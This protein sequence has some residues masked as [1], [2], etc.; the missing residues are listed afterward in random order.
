MADAAG[1]QAGALKD[2]QPAVTD[3][4]YLETKEYL[5]SWYLLDVDSEQRA[6]EIAAELPTAV[7]PADRGVADP[8]RGLQ[9]DR[10]RYGRRLTTMPDA[11]SAE[12]LLR[13]LAPQVL[14]VLMRRYDGLDSCEDAVQEALLDAAAQWPATG[15]P[16]NPRGWL[17]TVATRRLTDML[18][19][20]SARRRREDAVFRATPLAELAADAADAGSD[21]GADAITTTRSPCC[22]CAATRR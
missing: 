6:L 20:E 9:R 12:D 4:P 16:D 19:S 7:V 2:G 5:A 11:T 13:E 10:R 15:T 22:S 21:R 1:D 14:G 3:G 17:L 8:A 18:R